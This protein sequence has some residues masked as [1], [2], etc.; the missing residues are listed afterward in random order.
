MDVYYTRLQMLSHE[1]SFGVHTTVSLTKVTGY[2][3]FS[4]GTSQRF[5]AVTDSIPPTEANFP[6]G[7]SIRK[8]DNWLLMISCGPSFGKFGGDL[9]L[10]FGSQ[11]CVS[12]RHLIGASVS[13]RLFSHM[14]KTK[15]GPE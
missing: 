8:W 7:I 1:V 12:G 9:R 5:R 14:A 13:T 3:I 11:E 4:S 10:K 6:A 15:K 2:E